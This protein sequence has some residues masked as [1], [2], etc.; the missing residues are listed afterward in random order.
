MSHSW[1]I[2]KFNN[3]TYV[4]NNII[5]DYEEFHMF[6]TNDNKVGVSWKEK[7]KKK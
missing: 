6:I 4:N 1:G 5:P 3:D 7:N 2:V